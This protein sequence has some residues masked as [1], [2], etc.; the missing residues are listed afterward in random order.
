MILPTN[1]TS[2]SA[3]AQ[4]ARQGSARQA[5]GVFWSVGASWRISEE[6][7]LKDVKWINNMTLKASYGVQGNDD[8]GTYYA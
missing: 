3:D 8:L 4:T 5:L 7:F 2:L 1:I 6:P